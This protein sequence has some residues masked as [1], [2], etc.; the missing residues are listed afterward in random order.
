MTTSV[1]AARHASQDGRCARH[2]WQVS[3]L[4]V[5]AQRGGRPKPVAPD[6]APADLSRLPG[7]ASWKDG[8]FV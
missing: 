3:W 7:N 4:A 5:K 6:R 1:L 8:R 2:V